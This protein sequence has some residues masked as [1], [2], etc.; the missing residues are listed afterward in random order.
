MELV[1]DSPVPAEDFT[2][3]RGARDVEVVDT[4][5]R[6]AFDGNMDELLQVATGRHHLVDINSEEAD[7][8]EIFLAYYR[9]D[10]APDV[11]EARD[12]AEAGVS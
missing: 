4:S 2:A 12:E 6:L 3:I 11:R 10:E 8:E 9:G 7:L 1:F 5:V